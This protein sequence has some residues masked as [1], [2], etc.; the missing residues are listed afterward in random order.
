MNIEFGSFHQTL[1]LDISTIPEEIIARIK[2][3]LRSKTINCDTRSNKN[4]FKQQRR[5]HF[6]A[7]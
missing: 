5:C 1:L 7:G 3:K 4:T 2:A 6:K